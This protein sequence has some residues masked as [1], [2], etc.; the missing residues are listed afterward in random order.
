MPT[1]QILCC[2]K[3]KESYFVEPFLEYKKR[4]SSWI[5]TELIEL[6]T[7][8]L[9]SSNTIDIVKAK[10]ADIL[11]K[12]IGNSD[13]V[14][15]LSEE[16]KQFSSQEFSAVIDQ[17]QLKG[18]I[19]FI[20]GGTYGLDNKVKK[21]ADILLSFS[22]MTFTHEMIRVFLIEQIYRAFTILKN[23]EYHY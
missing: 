18:N 22:K 14:I 9:T 23:K 13:Y 20:I 4:L 21:R 12:N 3:T 17:A 1:I 7:V 5:N 11:L 15:V 16:G 2:G 10:E 8:S 19:K 6:P